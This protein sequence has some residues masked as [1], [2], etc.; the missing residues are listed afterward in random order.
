MSDTRVV[1]I[2]HAPKHQKH[3]ETINYTQLRIEMP[4]CNNKLTTNDYVHKNSNIVL[5]LSTT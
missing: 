3:A 2:E 1:V 5:T 4:L